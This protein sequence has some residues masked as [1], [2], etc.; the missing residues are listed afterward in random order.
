MTD[1]DARY[2]RTARSS[3]AAP[4]GSRSARASLFAVVFGAWLWWGGVLGAPAQ[5]EAQDIASRHP[6]P[7]ARSSVTWQVTIEPG[8]PAKCALQALN[9][10][11]GIVG[12][13]V[14]D[15]PASDVRTRSSP[16]RCAPPSPLSPA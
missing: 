13:N 8:T 7:D 3:Q 9:E 2:G 12:W 16:R 11:F 15:I 6:V 1:L 14:V 4:A 5:F 10:H